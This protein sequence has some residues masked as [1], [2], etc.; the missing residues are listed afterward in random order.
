MGA[1]A[2]PILDILCRLLPR[3]TRAALE[4]TFWYW[5]RSHAPEHSCRTG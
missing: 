2:D 1:I 3:A 5:H 4:A